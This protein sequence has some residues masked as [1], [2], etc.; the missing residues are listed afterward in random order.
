MARKSMAVAP[1]RNSP[2]PVP[3]ALAIAFLFLAGTADERTFGT[4]SDE[5][6]MLFTSVSIATAG[7]IGIARGPLF[8]VHRPAGDAVAPYGMGQ[9]LLQVLP[10][11]LA[12]PME[13]SS[14]AGS[15]QTLFVLVEILV[16]LAAAFG[17]SLAAGALGASQNARALA[18]LAVA[19][20]SPLSPYVSSNY[21]EPLQAAAFSFT[22]ACSAL[23]ACASGRRSLLLAAGAGLAAGVAV[24]TK[25]MNVAV[26]PFLLL[27]LLLDL[28]SDGAPSRPRLVM[29][30]TAGAFPP[31]ALWLA[32]E[33]V[34]FGRPFASYGG[35]NFTTPLFEGLVNLLGNPAE[36]LFLY[37]P[38]ALLAF[39][40]FAAIRGSGK[41][42][43][44]LGV[45]LATTASF[46]LVAAWWSWDGGPGW[47]PRLLVPLVPVLAALAAPFFDRG[48]FARKLS[49]GLAALGFGINLP[50]VLQPDAA[51][52]AYVMSM[53]PLAVSEAE[54][55]RYPPYFL[56]RDAAGRPLVPRPFVAYRDLTLLPLRLHSFLLGARLQGNTS[57]TVARIEA[58][59]PWAASRP[60]LAPAGPAKGGSAS[61]DA[62]LRSPFAW[63]HLGM[64]LSKPR[65]ERA[66]AYNMAY[67]SGLADQV[68]RAVDVGER[69]RAMRLS[70]GLYEISPSG[71]TA[72][73]HAEALRAAGRPQTLDSFLATLPPESQ[74]SPSLGVV[75]ALRAR[76]AGDEALA[77]DFLGRVATV[78]PR[79]GIRKAMASPLAAWPKNLHGMTGENLEE[80][81]LAAPE[82][83]RGDNPPK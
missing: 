45:A 34:R 28:R 26:A 14:G 73:L 35:Q 39:T 2:G 83:R 48:P 17:A 19:A 65:D 47:G 32:F 61:V 55:S 69:E 70:E 11:V 15:S 23:A 4:V 51:V 56:E 3:W 36:S 33:I 46:A 71:Y 31:L 64:S 22:L 63:P 18:L 58:R 72:A 68:L 7:E 75:L 40:A 30:A 8:T 81:A 44:L 29:A 62:H 59:P 79:P 27:P 57:E 49:I 9:P 1:R 50:G 78:F 76:D 60:D 42:G 16:V 25:S 24:L 12:G 80:R 41:R 77:R 66:D 10:A 37:F 43:T 38:F 13:R 21:A 74:S 53:P 52:S 54:A 67:L 5:Q 6:Q 82:F 20:A